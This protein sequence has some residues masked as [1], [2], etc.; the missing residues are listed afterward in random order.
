[1]KIFIKKSRKGFTLI[2]LLIVIII[3]GVLSATMMMSSGSSVASARAEMIISN[4]NT[5]KN[6]ALSYLTAEFANHPTIE[7]FKTNAKTYLGE[8]AN[9]NGNT[10]LTLDKCQYGVE[11]TKA[12]SSIPDAA[13]DN[14]WF[15]YCD[16]SS[17]GNNNG[18]KTDIINK[19]VKAASADQLLS[20]TDG[21]GYSGGEKVYMRIK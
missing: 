8:T 7:G 3:L 6:A 15:V 21:A 5:I 16:F 18:E 9:T 4:M 13:T 20:G 14:K 17:F 12:T 11:H 1:M 2:E 10:L 19:L